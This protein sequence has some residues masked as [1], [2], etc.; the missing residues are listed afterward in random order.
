MESDVIAFHILIRNEQLEQVDT[1]PYLGSLITDGEYTTEFRI[2]LN[3]GQ[4]IRTSL[5]KIWKS[6]D[7]NEG[8]TNKNASVACSNVRLWKLDTQKE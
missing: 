7:F 8:T 3:R 4:A 5:Q 6:H 1:F 2:R